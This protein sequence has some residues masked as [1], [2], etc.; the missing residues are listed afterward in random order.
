MVKTE[1]VE[2]ESDKSGSGAQISIDW[3]QLQGLLP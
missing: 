2:Q 3:I 1:N